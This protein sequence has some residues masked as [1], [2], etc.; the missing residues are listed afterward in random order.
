[1]NSQSASMWTVIACLDKAWQE[2]LDLWLAII[3]LII[4]LLSV[5]SSSCNAADVSPDACPAKEMFKRGA[6]KSKPTGY[7]IQ[8][9]DISILAATINSQIAFRNLMIPLL[10]E[11]IRNSWLDTDLYVIFRQTSDMVRT[12]EPQQVPE[13]R[14]TLRYK[15]CQKDF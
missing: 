7:K 8:G 6:E 14:S 1:M 9:P 13:H 2:R 4:Y 10:A 3:F 5:I 12:E 15:L 11:N